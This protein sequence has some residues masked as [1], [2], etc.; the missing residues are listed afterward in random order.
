MRLAQVSRA[1]VPAMILIEPAIEAKFGRAVRRRALTAFLAQA[2][3]AVRLK[4]EISV[5]LTTDRDIRRLN[6]AFRNKD[7][8]TDV[9]SFPAATHHRG[10]GEHGGGRQNGQVVRDGRDAGTELAG[11][12]AISVETAARQAVDAGHALCAEL[13]VLLLH[14][15]LHLAGYDHEADE[16]QMARREAALRRRFGLSAGLIER[17]AGDGSSAGQGA[18]NG[19]KGGRS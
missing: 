3:A 13:E 5:L 15:V 1:G 16:G 19:R 17:T 12:L 18:A 14:G 11:D 2:A 10:H 4:G 7:K 6:R 8:A 9:L